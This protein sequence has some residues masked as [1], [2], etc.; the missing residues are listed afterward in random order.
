MNECPK[1][2]A[3]CSHSVNK[4]GLVFVFDCGTMISLLN[5]VGE[6]RSSKCYETQ[7]KQLEEKNAR[8]TKISSVKEEAN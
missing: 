6:L 7:I 2:G 4:E 5:D 1:C 3:T 8:L